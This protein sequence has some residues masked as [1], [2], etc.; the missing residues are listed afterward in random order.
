MAL[1]RFSERG[2]RW[3][4]QLPRDVGAVDKVAEYDVVPLDLVVAVEAVVPEE[5]A[6][7]A[8][9]AREDEEEYFDRADVIRPPSRPFRTQ[10][11]S[12]S[13]MKS[14]LSRKEFASRMSWNRAA[15]MPETG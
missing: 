1:E 13:S 4:S 6:E 8:D 15:L 7:D 5:E 9:T 12:T 14:N 2:R 3:P 10:L 11:V